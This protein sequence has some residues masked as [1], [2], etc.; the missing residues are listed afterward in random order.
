LVA[1]ADESDASF[2]YLKPVM[3]VVTNIDTDHMGTYNH[4]FNKLRQTFVDFLQQ[5]P[6]YGLTVLCADDPAVC[7]ILTQLTKPLLTYGLSKDADIRAIEIHQTQGQT[8][9]KVLRDQTPWLEITLN[10]AGHHNVRNA[11]AAIAI[12]HEVGI[13]DAAIRR[14]LSTFS[15]IDRRFQMHTLHT[16][17]GELLLI[18]DYGHHPQEILAVLQAIRQGWPH[19]RLIVAFQPHRYTRTYDLFQDFVQVLSMVD[20]LLL[21]DVY[22]AGEAVIAGA[23]GETL[24]QAIRRYGKINPLFITHPEQLLTTLPP[25]LQDQDIILTLGAGNIGTVATMLP[26]YL[27][28]GNRDEALSAT[29]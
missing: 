10:L 25:L 6:F 8:H 19:R 1:E 18:D 29:G 17:Y 21:F 14:A 23:E 11:L 12:A 3:A 28:A 26:T 15:G 7:S 27:T 5:L 9:F 4:D 22:A 20:V 13:S 16:R 24:H 2:L